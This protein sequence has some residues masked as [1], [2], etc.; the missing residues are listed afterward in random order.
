MDAQRFESIPSPFLARWDCSTSMIAAASSVPTNCF[1]NALVPSIPQIVASE[2]PATWG[3]D[4][5]IECYQDDDFPAITPTVYA[6]L[7]HDSSMP[8][9]KL[10]DSIDTQECAPSSSAPASSAPPSSLTIV[11]VDHTDS[12]TSSSSVVQPPHPIEQ[13]Q[14]PPS[15]VPLVESLSVQAPNSVQSQQEQQEQ[16][17]CPPVC[18]SVDP[19]SSQPSV[20]KPSPASRKRRRDPDTPVVPSKRTPRKS[21]VNAAANIH[22]QLIGEE[23]QRMRAM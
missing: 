1:A 12:S 2:V 20:S 7:P 4:E 19:V 23:E 9:L 11:P 6:T 17:E 18:P 5:M 16:L 21:A 14:T 22:I 15:V 3:A 13:V 10:P 8:P